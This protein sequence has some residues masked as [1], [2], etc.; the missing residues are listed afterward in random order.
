LRLLQIAHRFDL[1]V[2]SQRV[3]V[4]DPT[5]KATPGKPHQES[6]VELS[7]SLSTT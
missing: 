4:P 5:K 7:A 2:W 3:L 6:I 1:Q